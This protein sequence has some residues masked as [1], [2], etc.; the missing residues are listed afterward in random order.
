MESNFVQNPH[1]ATKNSDW[2]AISLIAGILGLMTFPI[3]GSL[4]AIIS[5]YVAK[6]DIRLS[7]GKL[8]GKKM[9]TWGLVLGWIGIALVFLT[10]LILIISGFAILSSI[11]NFFD[12][13][14]YY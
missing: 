5:G 14:F 9:A 1:T 4:I 2:A 11:P 6:S 8:A 13:L 7:M 10:I 3:F 12:Q